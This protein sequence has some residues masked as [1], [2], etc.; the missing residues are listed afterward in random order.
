[1][2]L[3]SE[4]S[5]ELVENSDS[6]ARIDIFLARIDILE[7]NEKVGLTLLSEWKSIIFIKF[8][9]NEHK[10]LE[11]LPCLFPNIIF[12]CKKCQIY[13]VRVFVPNFL[14]GR[15]PRVEFYPNRSLGATDKKIYGK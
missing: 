6:I 11:Y 14:A 7:K 9:V 3:Y 5:S 4:C 2:Y 1:M 8:Y 10:P 13:S 15:C 12:S